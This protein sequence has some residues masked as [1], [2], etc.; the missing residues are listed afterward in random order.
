MLSTNVELNSIFMPDIGMKF[1]NV[2][3]SRYRGL[4]IVP[5][6]GWIYRCEHSFTD[7]IIV[8]HIYQLVVIPINNK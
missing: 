3:V 2:D 4:Q 8:L 6:S 7:T 1:P 5:I